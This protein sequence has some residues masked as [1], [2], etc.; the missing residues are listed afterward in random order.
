MKPKNGLSNYLQKVDRRIEPHDVAK[1]MA[2]DAPAMLSAVNFGKVSRQ[3]NPAAQHTPHERL[4]NAFNQPD[5]RRT[6]DAKT[7][8]QAFNP[9]LQFGWKILSLPSQP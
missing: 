6:P 1:L 9:T 5:L 8:K 7:G 4:A 3:I 2:Q